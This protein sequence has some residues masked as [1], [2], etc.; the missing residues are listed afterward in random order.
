MVV[1]KWNLHF[2]GF[3]NAL[4]G[5]ENGASLPL[6]VS[7]KSF[8]AQNLLVQD[9]SGLCHESSTSVDF[10]HY[11]GGKIKAARP[12]LSHHTSLQNRRI[13]DLDTTN[14]ILQDRS[15]THS[16]NTTRL[17]IKQFLVKKNLPSC[18]F[19][20]WVHCKYLVLQWFSGQISFNLTR[21]HFSP[22]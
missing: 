9:A 14:G 18:P 22:I 11:Q 15:N 6:V 20:H 19:V 12:E 16:L 2:N 4:D 7:E 8:V 3:L 5:V 17:W 1:K 13:G 10:T 21:T